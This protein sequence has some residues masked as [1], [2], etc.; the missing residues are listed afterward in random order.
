L[1]IIFKV[2]LKIDLPLV[3]EYPTKMS[4]PKGIF[5]S[6]FISEL[7]AGLLKQITY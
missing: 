5:S 3:V 7:A 2:I 1:L 4:A 6:A